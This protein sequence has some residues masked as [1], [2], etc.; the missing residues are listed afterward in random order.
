MVSQGT[1]DARRLQQPAGDEP[2]RISE[3]SRHYIHRRRSPPHSR[4]RPRLPG[5]AGRGLTRDLLARRSAGASSICF[6]HQAVQRFAD[7]LSRNRCA[8]MCAVTHGPER[9]SGATFCAAALSADRQICGTSDRVHGDQLGCPTSTAGVRLSRER[10]RTGGALWTRGTQ[11]RGRGCTSMCH[12]S[13]STTSSPTC[14]AWANGVRSV[15]LVTGSRAR[16]ARPSVR[17]FG[18]GTSTGSLG[19][20][21][22]PRWSPPDRRTSRS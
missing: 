22:S 16:R 13:A 14:A 15:S 11:G 19:G 3:G 21:R 12:Q 7:A 4:A 6:H 2:A 9:R 5:V 1:H 20:R 10:Y 17:A 8:D 18:V